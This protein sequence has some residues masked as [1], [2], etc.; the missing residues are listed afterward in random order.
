[1]QLRQSRETGSLR[2]DPRL[3]PWRSLSIPPGYLYYPHWPL[4]GL[5]YTVAH[6]LDPLSFFELY[7]R[8]TPY[9]NPEF[10]LKHLI[11]WF[12]IFTWSLDWFFSCQLVSL[13]LQIQA[14]SCAVP[15]D[16]YCC[17][18]V[19]KFYCRHFFNIFLIENIWSVVDF[20]HWI[21]YPF[22]VKETTDGYTAILSV[23][24]ML[25]QKEAFNSK[26]RKKIN[27]SIAGAQM[28]CLHWRGALHA[29]VE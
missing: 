8:R 26:Y 10:V 7:I 6:H 2:Q 21:E 17:M 14:I 27:A 18:P 1:M 4:S 19:S 12:C 22:Q 5:I 23:L 24:N 13:E 28:L 20:L 11:N 15:I 3:P 29:T 25:L 16:S 9:F